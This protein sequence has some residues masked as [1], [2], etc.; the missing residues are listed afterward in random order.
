MTTSRVFPLHTSNRPRA[1]EAWLLLG[2]RIEPIRRTGELRYLHAHFERP[3][4]TNGKRSDPPAK[5][6]SRIN[7]LQKLKA[8][9]DSTW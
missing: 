2:G 3:L 8:A 6:L 9:N 5:L 4:R 1:D 7:Q